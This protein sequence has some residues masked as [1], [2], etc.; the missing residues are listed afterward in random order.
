MKEVKSNVQGICFSFACLF[1]SLYPAFFL[2]HF[3]DFWSVF[4]V[5]PFFSS[6]GIIE[7]NDNGEFMNLVKSVVNLW[8]S[9]T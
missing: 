3:F 4:N 5:L 9:V 6:E 1:S 8:Q 2:F 7:T